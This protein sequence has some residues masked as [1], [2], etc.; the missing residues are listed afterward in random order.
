MTKLELVAR[1]AQRTGPDWTGAEA[2]Q[3][4]AQLTSDQSVT[5]KQ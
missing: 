2:V 3:A 4:I 5:E 1:I